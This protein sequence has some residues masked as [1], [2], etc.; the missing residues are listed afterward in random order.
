MQNLGN[1][2]NQYTLLS[3][4]YGD[5]PIIAYTARHNQNNNNYIIEFRN[6]EISAIEINILNILRNVNNPNILHIIE[7]GDG[8]LTLNNQQPINRPFIIFENAPKFSLFQYILIG[9]FSERHAKF[10]FRKI[11]NG[12][13]AMHNANICHRDIKCDNILFDENY[14]PK[15]FSF[16]FSCLN[17]NNLQQFVGTMTYASPQ[18]LGNLPYDGKKSD[19]FSLG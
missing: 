12:I 14:N 15:I 10:I 5:P 4:K 16:D 3:V 17:A 7:S 11:L 18:I 9:R 8:Q 6:N 2:N 19:I 1:L 13:R